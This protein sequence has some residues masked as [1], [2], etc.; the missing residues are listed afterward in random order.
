[1]ELNLYSQ[2]SVNGVELQIGDLQGTTFEITNFEIFVANNTSLGSFNLY[3]EVGEGAL[4]FLF[5]SV[6]LETPINKLQIGS[7]VSGYVVF[8]NFRLQPNVLSI[9]LAITASAE[10][11]EGV[12][13]NRI[14]LG[15]SRD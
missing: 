11:A 15:C 12:F 2:Y 14:Y 6:I 3:E 4:T 8:D 1:M 10:N 5:F 7:G 13:L 9:P